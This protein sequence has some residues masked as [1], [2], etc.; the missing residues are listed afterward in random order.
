[1]TK[2]LSWEEAARLVLQDANG[3][4]RCVEIAEQVSSRGLKK[5]VGAN[6]AA[7]VAAILSKSLSDEDSPFLRVGRG[8]YTLKASSA[9]PAAAEAPVPTTQEET[10]ETGALRAF[11]MYWKRDAVIWRGRPKL[12]GRQ[13]P[14]ATRVNFANQIGVYLLHDR[15]RVLYVGRATDAL[16]A[17]L[18]AH[19]TDRLG[20]RWDR[21]SWFGLRNVGPD[22]ELVDSTV[23]WD[24]MVVIETLE[25]LL[26]ES[27]EPPLNRRRGDNFS[28]V[29]YLQMIDPEIE[30][31]QQKR[32]IDQLSR[33][34]AGGDTEM[35]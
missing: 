32:V 25:A 23:P 35:V 12:L 18:L 24:Q 30:R 34:I 4:L 5:S 6:P 21:F 22:G 14:A 3:A 1:V 9:Q 17:R 15:D 19:T 8:E 16:V 7:S 28:G 27:L 33:S 11:G 26:I 10:S 2:D 20:G 31:L 13:G 29:E